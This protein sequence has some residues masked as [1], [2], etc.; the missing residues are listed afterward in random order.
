MTSNAS[1]LDVLAIAPHP[2]D[3]ELACGGTLLLAKT[4]GLSTGILDLTRGEMSTRGTL[5]TRQDEM[6]QASQMLELDFRETLNLGDGKLENTIQNQD[7]IIE[8]IRRTKP[9]IC[10]IGAESD[11]HPDHEKAHELAK[12]AL[13]YAGLAKRKVGNSLPFRPPHV[14]FYMHHKGFEPDL[15]MDISNVFTK[16][17]EVIATFSSQFNA[18]DKGPKTY[19]SSSR[20]F[21][22]IEGRARWFG[23][24]IG[25]EFGEPFRYAHGPIPFSDFTPLLGQNPIR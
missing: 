4:Q 17:M 6:A 25:V 11:R 18:E 20:F 8:A 14:L 23:Q 22:S 19:I 16:K 3:A 12:Q 15:V 2:D 13:F 1:S 7:A 21:K 9:K 24:H 5:S 10:L